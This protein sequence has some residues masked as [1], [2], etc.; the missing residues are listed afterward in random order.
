MAQIDHGARSHSKWGMSALARY[1]ACP[2]SV[3]LCEQAGPQPESSAAADGTRAHEVLEQR[4]RCL[5][6]DRRDT[7]V[8]DADTWEATQVA[9][10]YV[11]DVLDDHPDA[12]LLVEQEFDIPCASTPGQVWGIAD[13]AIYLPSWRQ[14]T[15]LDYK[16]GAGVY[17]PA[18]G[19]MQTRGYAFGVLSAHPEWD[20]DSVVLAVCQPR[21]YMAGGVE[22]WCVSANEI[23]AFG[24]EIDAAVRATLDPDAPLVPG[25][26]QCRFCDAA[27]I[28]PALERQALESVGE[29]FSS[30][31]MVTP[32]ALQEPSGMTPARVGEVLAKA[33][34]LEAWIEKVK[35]R[36]LAL[37]T[38]GVKVPGRKLVESRATRKF[39]LPNDPDEL[40]VER[41]AIRLSELTDH[42]VHINQFLPP[43][44]LGIMAAEK[45][46]KDDAR[47]QA[48]RGKKTQ[49]VEEV[50]GK[51]AFM[52]TK[53]SSGKLSLVA[54]DDPRPAHA[55]GV[56]FNGTTTLLP[57][58][59]IES[60]QS[61]EEKSA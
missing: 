34:L 2:G 35:E 40:D 17:V 58:V 25:E 3:R 36:G 54:E 42:R 44:L 13:V 39:D 1:S 30:V 21:H 57:Q 19:N 59:A 47:A 14:L 38:A 23:R 20:V 29:T 28:C 61:K 46:I 22:E 31:V 11:R 24:A 18:V 51:L 55:P 41:V 6:T 9:V 43:T 10:D 4:L 5:L 32:E 26:K 7:I 50:G 12:V 60:Q 56:V 16:H 27:T 37:A 49:A 45:L 52:T 33:N 53:K 48:P 8:S 15:V